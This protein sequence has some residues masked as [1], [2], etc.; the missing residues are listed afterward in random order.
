MSPALTGFAGMFPSL[1]WKHLAAV[2]ERG[3]HR[4]GL[5][6]LPT[7]KGC[8]GGLPD[9]FFSHGNRAVQGMGALLPVESETPLQWEHVQSCKADNGNACGHVPQKL[10][11]HA[12]QCHPSDKVAAKMMQSL[13]CLIGGRLCP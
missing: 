3:I 4:R 5:M 11:E 13:G 9:I 2:P 6:V 8:S 1:V 12:G 7:T 10:Q